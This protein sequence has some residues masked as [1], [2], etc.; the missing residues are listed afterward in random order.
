MYRKGHYGVSLLVF[1]PVGFAL[2]AAGRP[3]L[4]LLTGGTMVWLATLPDADLRVPGLTHR[5]AT[6]T[7]G[8]AALVGAGFA[9]AGVLAARP[10]GA[11]GALFGTYG[12]A[13]GALAVVAHLVADLLTPAGVALLWPLSGRRYSLSVTTA[14]DPVWNYGLLAVGVL[15][16]TAAVVGAARI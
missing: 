13:L 9:L 12:F 10:L 7:L 16:A 3:G 4:A 6:H 5:G 11:D 8:F 2:V 14:D 15:A 1:A